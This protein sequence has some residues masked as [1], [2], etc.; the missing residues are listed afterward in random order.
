MALGFAAYLL[1]MRGGSHT[2]NDDKAGHY[3]KLWAEN[4]PAEVVHRSLSDDSLWGT[5]LTQLPGFEA[6]V[7]EYL[8]DLII[9][10]A[11]ATLARATTKNLVL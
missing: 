7:Q 9:K 6:V 5:D 3:V 1:F 8:E 4:T 10:G 11:T 2:V